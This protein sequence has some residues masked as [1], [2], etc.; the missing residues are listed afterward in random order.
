MV[1]VTAPEVLNICKRAATRTSE[2]LS[3]H[4]FDYITKDQKTN[5]TV[6]SKARA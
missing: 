2:S 5:V 4:K 3:P 1:V 6:G